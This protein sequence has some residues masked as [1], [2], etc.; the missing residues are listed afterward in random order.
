MRWQKAVFQSRPSRGYV[1]LGAIDY[2]FILEPVRVGEL[3]ETYSWV[4]GSTSHTVDVLSYGV[5][6]SA[7]GG[8]P[9]PVSL[10]IQTYVAVDESVRPREHGASIRACSFEGE[11]LKNIHEEWLRERRELVEKRHE[12]A[13]DTSRLNV[14]Y[15]VES[16]EI[17][18]PESTF[19]L[20]RVLDATK[21]FYTIDS[22][23]ALAAMKATGSPVVTAS[24][25]AAVFASPAY[26]GDVLRAEAGVTGVGR[27][28]LEVLVK[29]VA[30]NPI[31]ERENTVAQLYM[32]LVSIGPDG[33]PA[34][35]RKKPQIPEKLQRGF[36][37]RRI[38][39]QKKRERIKEILHL[40]EA[41][42]K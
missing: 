10:S 39:R 11:A 5:A 23:G 1:V 27:T 29:V 3:F 41:L 8:S 25:D 16:Y 42:P 33:R 38:V 40:V 13:R 14:P 12:V 36:E 32:V 35:P 6:S 17:V 26:V 21:F 18:Y 34:E 30:E 31:E 37:L 15:R 2:L 7:G 22:L 19:S 20:P 4:I 9:R 24:F 28:S